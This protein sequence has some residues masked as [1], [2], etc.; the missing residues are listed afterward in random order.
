[1]QSLVDKVQS[2]LGGSVGPNGNDSDSQ[3]PVTLGESVPG[4]RTLA[5]FEVRSPLANPPVA[6]EQDPAPASNGDSHPVESDVQMSGM[7]HETD[8]SADAS[9]MGPPPK[10]ASAPMTQI[11][12][13]SAVTSLPP[14]V[15][16]SAVINE[17]STTKTS[18]PSTTNRSSNWSTQ[19]TNG[20]HGDQRQEGGSG[21]NEDSMEEIPDTAPNPS[22]A[23]SSD[24]TW[25]HSQAQALRNNAP[26]DSLLSGTPVSSQ[27]Y[28]QQ[29]PAS[30]KSHHGGLGVRDILNDQP[31]DN[32]HQSN[33]SSQPLGIDLAIESFL[34][35][36]TDKTS[37]CTIEQLEQ[38]NRE[39]MDEI[40]RSRNEWN[41]QT[42]LA[43]VT[44]VFN[45][46]IDDIERIQGMGPLSQSQRHLAA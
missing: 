27:S 30:A 25:L 18:D 5:R 3:G 4:S 21:E 19:L 35:N 43:H 28:Q 22:Q 15:S 12:Q 11:S 36:M 34:E 16:P 33:S 7:D 24:D 32:T 9:G 40:W 2:D 39:L 46:T 6:A 17:A 10:T 37:G 23:T 45:Q 13:K 8:Q 44:S 41:R 26:A 42:V 29:T 31:G 1:M 20:T 38:I 14:G